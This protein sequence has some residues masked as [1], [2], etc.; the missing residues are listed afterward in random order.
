M[1]DEISTRATRDIAFLRDALQELVDLVAGVLTTGGTAPHDDHMGFMAYVYLSKQLDHAIGILRLDDHPDTQLI[2]RSMLEGRC[3]LLW[4]YADAEQRALMWR[5][6][7]V[8]VDW[9]TL[10]AQDAKGEAVDA[11]TRATVMRRAAES[12]EQFRK[13]SSTARDPYRRE[14]HPLGSVRAMFSA[15]DSM[16]LYEALYGPLSQWHHWSPGGAGRALTHTDGSFVYRAQDDT[17]HATA[18]AAA[19]Q[20]LHDTAAI[21]DR[22][23][24]IG[25]GT[26][27]ADIFGRYVARLD[28]N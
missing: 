1:S 17:M 12:G 27:L 22:V 24:N 11:A 9:R 8:I 20:C 21:A 4:A 5:E 25:L 28:R 10:Q 6:F 14:W 23:L 2:A 19:L 26:Q 15:T 7:V 13:P 16:V 18:L 3:Q